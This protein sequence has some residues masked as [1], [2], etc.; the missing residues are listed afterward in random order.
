GIAAG[1]L[2]LGCKYDTQLFLV[3]GTPKATS[4]APEWAGSRVQAYR[5]LGRTGFRMS[6]ISFG[7]AGLGDA[8]VARR[9]VERGITYFDTSPDYSRAGSEI[10]LGKGVAG[11]R[12]EGL[13]PRSQFCTAH[14]PLAHHPPAATRLPS[15]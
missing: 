6:D 11:A 1:G 13:F 15:R 8:E 4:Q 7:C 12:R 3:G 9:G 2:A 10:A 5:P 14:R